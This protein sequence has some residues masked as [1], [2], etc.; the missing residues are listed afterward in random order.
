MSFP[1]L[2][3]F[4]LEPFWFKVTSAPHVCFFTTSSSPVQ[5][6]FVIM[7]VKS[8]F[9][10]APDEKWDLGWENMGYKLG[11]VNFEALQTKH[12]RSLFL[13]FPK[14]LPLGLCLW[15]YQHSLIVAVI[16]KSNDI[17]D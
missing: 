15:C 17:T 8:P 13:N 9:M 2:W 7:K 11:F 10:A 1:P 5:I 4:S 12:K 3:L 14:E 16:V 6:V